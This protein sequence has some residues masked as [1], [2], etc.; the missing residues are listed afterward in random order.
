MTVPAATWQ[1]DFAEQ[2]NNLQSTVLAL[3]TNQ[4]RSDLEQL[5]QA[6]RLKQLSGAY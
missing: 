1:M 3:A 4:T 6:E 5:R 2:L